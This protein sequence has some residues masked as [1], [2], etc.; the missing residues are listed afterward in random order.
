MNKY[1]LK[2]RNQQFPSRLNDNWSSFPATNN[3]WLLRNITSYNIVLPGTSISN[4]TQIVRA[5]RIG[6]LVQRLPQG[7][8]TEGPEFESLY[9][10]EICHYVVQTG[11][12]AHPTSYPMDTED[13]FPR[14]KTAGFEA[15]HSPPTR[16]EVKNMWIYASTPPYAFML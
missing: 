5:A 11:S 10:Q 7:W 9:G 6:Y 4:F 2:M 16:A 8:T 12:E 13:S 14:G 1:L 3:R 15:D